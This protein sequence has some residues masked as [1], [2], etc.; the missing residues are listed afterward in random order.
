[1]LTIK[2]MKPNFF[3]LGAQKAGTTTLFEIL[4]HH[5]DVYVPA[6][7]EMHFFSNED[8]YIKG[9]EWYE[10]KYY[11][12]SGNKKIRS[13][14]TPNYLSYPGC[15]KRIYDLI[16]PDV[17]L[18]IVLRQPIARAYS[19]YLMYKAKGY[20]NLSFFD[21]LKEEEKRQND[22]KTAEKYNYIGKGRYNEQI[23]EYLNY[24][25][26][27]NIMF[28]VFEYDIVKNMDKTI[29]DIE[30]FLNINHDNALDKYLN[31]KANSSREVK[32]QMFMSKIQNPSKNL[33]KFSHFMF[34]EKVR[35]DI[36]K[37]MLKFGTKNIENTALGDA[38]VKMLT[39]KYYHGMID[40][41]ELIIEK[42]LSVWR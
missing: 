4:K 39:N 5:S 6:D 10:S 27:K 8:N 24:F 11:E 37:I 15:A 18:L 19:H 2:Y 21:A 29:R 32:W 1:M 35:R 22:A 3:C 26:R 23:K 16:G 40:A 25:D 33:K 42:D 20:E 30:R 17:K 31:V 12:E 9:I 14:F 36:K 13:D 38:E 28:L 41:I 7:K 34:S